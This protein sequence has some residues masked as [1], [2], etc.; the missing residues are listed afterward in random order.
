MCLD[1]PDI[2]RFAMEEKDKKMIDE[3]VADTIDNGVIESV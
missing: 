3:I 1:D 2:S